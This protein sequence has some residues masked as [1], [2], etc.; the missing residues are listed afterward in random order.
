MH[1][2]GAKGIKDQLLCQDRI[3]ERAEM[4]GKR[5]V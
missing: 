5:V 4:E 1:L 2:F 3:I